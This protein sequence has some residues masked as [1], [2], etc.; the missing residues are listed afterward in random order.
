[1]LLLLFSVA[2]HAHVCCPLQ[3]SY[4]DTMASLTIPGL[5]SGQR[6]CVQVG[7]T[8]FRKT[9]GLPSCTRCLMVPHAGESDLL[10]RR[11]RCSKTDFFFW[12]IFSFILFTLFV[13]AWPRVETSPTNVVVT[14][15]LVLVPMVA[16][17][18][19]TVYVIM[20]RYGMIKRWLSLNRYHLPA[21]VSIQTNA[22]TL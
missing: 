10:T 5:T 22:H 15:V 21:H 8:L 2:L 4:I 20:F 3:N 14:V 17:L 18:I 9:Y 13:L 11:R 19:A 16:I 1:M 6:Y 7:F 12:F